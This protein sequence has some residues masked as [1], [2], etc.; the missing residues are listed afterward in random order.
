MHDTLYHR[1]LVDA[2]IVAQGGFGSGI[3]PWRGLGL[4]VARRMVDTFVE[5]VGRD[6]PVARTEHPFLN[7]RDAYEQVFPQYANIYR[8]PAPTQVQ[9]D[10]VLRAD[11]LHLNVE[12]LRW[13]RHQGPVVATGGLLRQLR[14]SGT[15]LFRERYIWPAVQLNHLLPAGEGA[16]TLEAYRQVL[17]RTFAAFGLPV[18]TI[19]TDALSSYGEVCHLTV[20]CL[21]DG[22]PTVLATTYLMASRYREALG[23]TGDLVDIGFTGKVLALVSMH[24]LDRGGLGLPSVLAPVQAG[25]L[26]P[27]GAAGL[28]A[29]TSSLGGIRTQRIAVAGDVP[30]RR[31]RAERGLARTG[32]PLA[33]GVRPDGSWRVGRRAPSCYAA[34]PPFPDADAVR[35]ELG[36]YD[37][38]QL[39]AA[40]ARL[41][42]SVEGGGLVRGVCDGCAAARRVPVFGRMV[43]RRRAR[44]THCAAPGSDHFVSEQGRFY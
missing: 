26:A 8:L 44:C 37:R 29:W 31:R 13:H 14:G 10:W 22:R 32:T 33:Y 43:P 3:T 2:G 16:A 18:L 40:R 11:N 35:A 4:G 9:P 7:R 21:R 25:I 23:V 41:R 17:E 1:A 20:S 12:W 36:A 15:P 19:A 34:T 24:Q 6:F 28:D 42:R 30:F 38:R 39:D 27:Q 5:Q